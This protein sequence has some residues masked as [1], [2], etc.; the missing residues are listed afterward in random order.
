MI[1]NIVTAKELAKY[2][3]LSD[4]TIYKLASD[5]D[6]PGFKIGDSWRFDMD[7]VVKLIEKTKRGK[8]TNKYEVT[9]AAVGPSSRGERP[10]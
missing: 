1:K 7:G 10:S 6:L 9:N 4:S 8:K 2:L 3:K 5:G